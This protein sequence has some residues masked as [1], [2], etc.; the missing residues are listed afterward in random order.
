MVRTR[1]TAECLKEPKIGDGKG[2]LAFQA[3]VVAEAVLGTKA[4]SLEI[5]DQA[6]EFAEYPK[7]V[8]KVYA[9]LERL[10]PNFVEGKT[11]LTKEEP[12]EQTHPTPDLEG[13]DGP[14][15]E[16]EKAAVHQHEGRPSEVVLP[17]ITNE[18]SPQ[19]NISAAKVAFLLTEAVGRGK[20]AAE[21]SK[22]LRQLKAV[23][24]SDGVL[25]PPLEEL[26]AAV[27]NADAGRITTAVQEMKKA[28][29]KRK[30]DFDLM[31]QMGIDDTTEGFVERSQQTAGHPEDNLGDFKIP[32]GA[33]PPQKKGSSD[34]DI[35]QL[36]DPETESLEEELEGEEDELIVLDDDSMS[37]IDS[38]AEENE[39]DIDGI[40][41]DED[42][43]DDVEFEDDELPDEGVDSAKVQSRIP[44]GREASVVDEWGNAFGMPS[45]AEMQLVDQEFAR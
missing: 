40:P 14:D 15:P 37:D 11:A 16:P 44:R 1:L 31:T 22:R 28:L 35:E 45:E 4:D 13:G 36:Q 17:T 9:R 3:T 19:G 8:G 32:E 21:L 10:H 41:M 5:E 34:E 2:T 7:L 6:V 29:V 20:K 26:Q 24:A 42:T 23:V 33:P 12:A 43:S 39:I 30:G 38:A 18:Q 27:Q 25:L